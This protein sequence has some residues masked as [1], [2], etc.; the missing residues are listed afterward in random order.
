[1]QYSLKVVGGLWEGGQASESFD[2]DR[3]S[4]GGGGCGGTAH[5]PIGTASNA[6]VALKFASN[7]SYPADGGR[8]Q[9]G[10]CLVA[11]MVYDPSVSCLASGCRE[12]SIWSLGCPARSEQLA[13]AVATEAAGQAIGGS[14]YA[15]APP[16]DAVV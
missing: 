1:M 8:W 15:A 4:F 11:A 12:G 10:S 6:L 13:A 14:Q 16:Q 9:P 3:W 7:P 5:P 2:S